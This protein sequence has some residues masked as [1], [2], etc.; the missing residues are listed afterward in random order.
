[1]KRVVVLAMQVFGALAS[2]PPTVVRVWHE[3]EVSNAK[4]GKLYKIFNVPTCTV[5]LSHNP[6]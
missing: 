5:T 4:M 2:H 3:L 6:A 1:M